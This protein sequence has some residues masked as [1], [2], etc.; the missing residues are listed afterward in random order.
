MTTFGSGGGGVHYF[1]PESASI[2][3][4]I[5]TEANCSVDFGAYFQAQDG[6]LFFGS[7]GYCA[8]YP[9]QAI[10]DSLPPSIVFADF[11]LLNKSVPIGDADK[12]SPLTKP[13]YPKNADICTLP[14]RPQRP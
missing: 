7:R 3:T 2:T 5:G 12:P 9:E 8:F 11:R 13:L 14:T 6:K 4:H 10:R 1:D